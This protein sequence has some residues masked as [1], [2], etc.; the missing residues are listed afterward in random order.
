[1]TNHDSQGLIGWSFQTAFSIYKE[2]FALLMGL[3]ILSLLGSFSYLSFLYWFGEK[4]VALAML[5]GLLFMPVG[6][7]ALIVSVQSIAKSYYHEPVNLRQ[8]LAGPKGRFWRTIGITFGY[9]FT[10]TGP[11]MSAG[12]FWSM[13]VMIFAIVASA[14]G[15][16][17]KENSFFQPSMIWSGVIFGAIALVP[18]IYL[19]I[20]FMFSEYAVILEERYVKPFQNSH[21][22]VFGRFWIV[23]GGT[24]LMFLVFGLIPIA[25]G[26][27]QVI[28]KNGLTPM[29]KYQINMGVTVYNLFVTPFRLAFLTVLYLE[30]KQLNAPAPLQPAISESIPTFTEHFRIDGE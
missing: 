24:F 21:Q 4:L 3:S 25:A 10:A 2:K 8:A 17:I 12:V 7:W 13:L 14:S 22:L 20:T 9:S 29:L 1:M 18:V 15:A 5:I 23:A 16:G 30:L 27:F 11:L 19:L 26:L 28:Y 6:F